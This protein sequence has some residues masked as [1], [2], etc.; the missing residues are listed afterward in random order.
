M[1][2]SDFFK[3]GI[4]DGLFLSN[5]QP[6]LSSALSTRAHKD[7]KSQVVILENERERGR[8]GPSSLHYLTTSFA[9][10]HL[11]FHKQ[12]ESGSERSRV[13]KL[14]TDSTVSRKERKRRTHLPCPPTSPCAAGKCPSFPLPYHTQLYLPQKR[15]DSVC[16]R[17]REREPAEHANTHPLA[18]RPHVE[19]I[20]PILCLSHV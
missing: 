9:A 15:M 11:P 12:H 3:P 16:C 18:L 7:E 8:S 6:P 10:L 4:H 1:K 13:H 17:R 20:I 19:P 2:R 5:L 14:K